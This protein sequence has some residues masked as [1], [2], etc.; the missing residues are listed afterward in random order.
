MF[1]FLQVHDV[2]TRE[3][4]YLYCFILQQENF[5]PDMKGSEMEFR[6]SFSFRKAKGYHK[7]MRSGY[8][9]S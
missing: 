2:F 6:E 1:Q 4:I 9:S 5:T 7:V 3:V 8:N